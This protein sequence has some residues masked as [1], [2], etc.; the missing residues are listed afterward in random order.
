MVLRNN[1]IDKAEWE[2][3]VLE[4]PYGNF[5][6][7][8]NAFKFFESVD[9]HKPFVF[10]VSENE[11][12]LGVL[13]GVVI[14]NGKG[15]KGF[16]SR[17]AIVWGG[18]LIESELDENKKKIVL[19]ELL[20]NLNEYCR[21]RAIYT[22]FRNFYDM[23][24]YQK[25]FKLKGYTYEKHL[26]FLVHLKN[27]D[28]NFSILKKDKKYELRKSKENGLYYKISDKEEEVIEFYSILKKL[29]KDKVK[30]PLNN[31]EFFID[32]FK[33]KDLGVIL[34]AMFKEKIIGGVVCPI[35]KGIIYEWYEAADSL[36]V[37]NTYPNVFATF[38]PIEY[39]I[40][41]NLSLFDMMGAG[42]PDEKYG[43]RDFK[44]KFGGELVEYG[45]FFKINNMIFYKIGEIGLKIMGT[46]K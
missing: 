3:F 6:Q 41:N 24:N 40:K 39:G 26:N 2:K 30:K 46:F 45:R 29:Y 13:S 11:E 35:F 10:A 5:F 27:Y 21:S 44:S 33:K 4:H 9:N 43:V 16:L 12:I 36:E 20:K 42:K 32:F 22:E 15:I 17:R 1:E 38:M 37:K 19:E 31:L 34:I 23:R 28:Y 8:V 7:S 25:V 18:P 14:S